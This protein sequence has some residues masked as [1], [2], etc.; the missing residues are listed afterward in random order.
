MLVSLIPLPTQQKCVHSKLGKHKRRET[1]KDAILS[2]PV[3]VDENL[4]LDICD[5]GMVCK[6]LRTGSGA[7][8]DVHVSR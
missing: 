5:G 3:A 4:D 7:E 6:R 1:E 2:Y 8:A